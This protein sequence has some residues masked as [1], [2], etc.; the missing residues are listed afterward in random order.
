VC[1][2]TRAPARH[3]QVKRLGQRPVAQGLGQLAV[4]R[5]TPLHP[6]LVEGGEAV[7][8]DV[9][10]HPDAAR[11]GRV[12]IDYSI[13]GL[14]GPEVGQV[15]DPDHGV[16]KPVQGVHRL[17]GGEFLE[18]IEVLPQRSWRRSRPEGSHAIGGLA[19]ASRAFC[20]AASA[21]PSLRSAPGP[22]SGR[23]A[24]GL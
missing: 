17:P 11:L 13:P 12:K 21:G 2:V 3:R 1:W 16:E 8:I 14:A 7:F 19:A 15:Q 4:H 20:K 22:A 9:L 18:E 10:E 6:Y 24:C 23:D 5:R